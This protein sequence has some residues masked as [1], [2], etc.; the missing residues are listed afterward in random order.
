M[1]NDFLFYEREKPILSSKRLKY[2][3]LFVC[4]SELQV[5][6]VVSIGY[7]ASCMV[8]QIRSKL[9][10]HLI[11]HQDCDNGYRKLR[12]GFVAKKMFVARQN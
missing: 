1:P 9:C 7:S 4:R 6:L 2:Q 12:E 3:D 11:V 10:C 8:K 5:S